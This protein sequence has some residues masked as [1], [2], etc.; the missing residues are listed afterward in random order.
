[1]Y[2]P[3]LK[4]LVAQEE[5]SSEE[6]KVKYFPKWDSLKKASDCSSEDNI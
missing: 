2:F 5:H 1:V 6:A 4:F 3:S